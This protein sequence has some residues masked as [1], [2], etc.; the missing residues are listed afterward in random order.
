MKTN[1]TENDNES[2]SATKSPAHLTAKARELPTSPP[3]SSRRVPEDSDN[4]CVQVAV[5]I[6]PLLS[7]EGS[8]EENCVSNRANMI[9]IGG[10]QGPR[11]TF[12]HVFTAA[13]NQATLFETRIRPLV[14]QC[15]EGY[16]ATVLAYGQTGSGKTHTILGSTSSTGDPQAGVLPRALAYLFHQLADNS[17]ESTQT[18]VSIQFLE[19]YGEEIRD[20][21]CRTGAKEKLTIRDYGNDEPEVVG[22]TQSSCSSAA[23]AMELLSH[24][25]LR[26]V[27]GAT[28]MNESSSRSHAIFA[29][30]VEQSTLPGND[31]NNDEEIQMKRSKFCFVDLAGAER[32]KRTQATGKRL[33]EG[34]DINKGLSN[35]GNVISALG[36]PRKRG[37][38]HVP[39]RDAK[40][41]RLLKGS[42]GGNHKTLMIACVSPAACNMGESLN[43]LR[44]ANRAKNIQNKAVVNVDGATK[45]IQELRD[46]V[47]ILA[48]DLLLAIDG[49]VDAL[50]HSKDQLVAISGGKAGIIP[51]SITERSSSHQQLQETQRELNETTQL[52]QRTQTNHDAAEEELVLTKAE[53]ARFDALVGALTESSGVDPNI[54]DKAFSQKAKSYEEEILG[55]RKELA[56]A[57]RRVSV[58]SN[59]FLEDEDAEGD[60]NIAQEE[61]YLVQQ[62][63]IIAKIMSPSVGKDIGEEILENEEEI[64]HEQVLVASSD[65]RAKRS[66]QY[67]AA[68]DELS[69]SIEAKERLIGQ[70]KRSKERES[71]RWFGLKSPSKPF[72][73]D[74]ARVLRKETRGASKRARGTRK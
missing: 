58:L 27:T 5:R 45:R 70:I 39:Y 9:Q 36:D 52:L 53:N 60:D 8:S 22:A 59:G 7:H 4:S 28:A 34:I 50:Q 37:K 17:T 30:S 43:C 73:K 65:D 23:E 62:K 74:V 55:L 21:L 14:H 15:L 41:T 56:E 47:Q 2:N 44:Y 57:Q 32:Q 11:F 68:L 63:E 72:A 69:Q 38:T 24:G 31:E 66:S 16:N 61:Q 42:L 26:R 13:D 54:I 71:V 1:E 19:L 6:R 33:Q 25:M 48:S 20:L 10:S 46:Q 35:L 64:N 29:V 49:K 51:S 3:H 12:D 18:T 40:L 67:S